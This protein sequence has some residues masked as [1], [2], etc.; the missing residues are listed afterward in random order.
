MDIYYAIFPQFALK[1]IKA[2]IENFG[3]PNYL[4]VASCDCSLLFYY[5]V[6]CNCIKSP[7]PIF[8]NHKSFPDAASI[9]AN[10]FRK[11]RPGY[12]S[13]QVSKNIC[14]GLIYAPWSFIFE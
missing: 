4:L 6:P 11:L 7:T 14:H 9:D 10:G 8:H 13:W 2:Q 1:N 3:L 12:W 5:V